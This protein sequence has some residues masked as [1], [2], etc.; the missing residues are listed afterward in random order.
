MKYQV[1]NE[2]IE[3]KKKA[4]AFKSFIHANSGQ[5]ITTAVDATTGSH[6]AQLWTVSTR[7]GKMYRNKNV[8]D[9]MKFNEYDTSSLSFDDEGRVELED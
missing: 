3:P 9:A 7:T 4:W 2:N 5:Y 8:L 1:W 6:I